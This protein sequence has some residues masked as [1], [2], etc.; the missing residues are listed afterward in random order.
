MASTIISL[1]LFLHLQV[2]PAPPSLF[3]KRERENNIVIR[4]IYLPGATIFFYACMHVCMY[5]LLCMY[6]RM[7]VYMYACMHYVCTYV[8]MYVCMYVCIMYIC[9]YALCMYVCMYVCMCV[10]M[11]VVYTYIYIHIYTYIYIHTYIY[12]YM[13]HKRCLFLS[14]CTLHYTH[15][16]TP[17]G[18]SPVGIVRP[19][20]FRLTP[21]HPPHPPTSDAH[22]NDTL[23]NRAIMC[24]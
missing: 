12:I 20:F 16:H 4:Y 14:V 11:Y 22:P 19:N 2:Y 1:N 17:C 7:Y 10:C 6:A 15:T 13:I 24:F 23:A 9:M 21:Q 3:F 8:C 5:I 18:R